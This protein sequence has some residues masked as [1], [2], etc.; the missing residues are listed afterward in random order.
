MLVDL[1]S[2]QNQIVEPAVDAKPP[3]HSPLFFESEFAVDLDGGLV[4]RP[5]PEVHFADR[6]SS[7]TPVKQRLG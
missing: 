5:H 7:F 4:V 3:R 1:Y 2:H 6:T